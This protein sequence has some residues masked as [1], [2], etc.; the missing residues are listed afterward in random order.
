MSPKHSLHNSTV[1]IILYFPIFFNGFR[2]I[3]VKNMKITVTIHSFK[4][5]VTINC[6]EKYKIIVK[7]FLQT[8]VSLGSRTMDITYLLKKKSLYLKK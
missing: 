8:E 5:V 1:S 6:N 2:K 7:K 4:F 3:F